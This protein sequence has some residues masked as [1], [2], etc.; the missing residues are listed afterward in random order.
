[1]KMLSNSVGWPSIFPTKISRE[2]YRLLFP[3]QTPGNIV[4][5]EDF[6]RLL[7][8]RK[9]KKKFKIVKTET[10]TQGHP[11]GATGLAQCTELTWQL[12]GWTGDRL[13]PNVKYALQHNVGLG[14]AIVIR[15]YKRPDGNTTQPHLGYNPATDARSITQEDYNKACSKTKR[16]K[17][18]K[19]KL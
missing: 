6:Q 14:G 5:T 15:I 7:L 1:M 11:L 17:F 2:P 3:L 4:P 8:S 13:I 9:D 16:A 10:D 19:A 18:L 12:R